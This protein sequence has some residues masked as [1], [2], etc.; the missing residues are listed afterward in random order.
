M[1]NFLQFLIPV[2]ISLLAIAFSGYQLFIMNQQFLFEKRMFLYRLYKTLL[3]H[4]EDA[5][6]YLND[7]PDNFCVYDMLIADLTND[8]ELES[9]CNGW[10]NES[11]LLEKS[12][13][14]NFLTTIEK[15]RTFGEES[16]FVFKI[17]NK[18]LNTYFN[19]YANL[20][21]KTYQ[22]RILMKNLDKENKSFPMDLE[23][24]KQKQKDLHKELICMYEDLCA[25]S[26]SIDIKKVAN[27][28]SFLG[29]RE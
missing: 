21:H 2:F 23:P 13:H 28:I 14:K 1:E 16:Y 20:L 19:Q 15:I 6:V 11:A 12:D 7:D 25:I 8:S 17:Y 24:T 27:S 22:Y 29:K 10:E 3:K 5:R 18:E 4:Q 9:M 26:K